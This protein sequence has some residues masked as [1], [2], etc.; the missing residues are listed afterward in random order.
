MMHSLELYL[1]F[2]NVQTPRFD[3]VVGKSEEALPIIQSFNPA[4]NQNV[5][6]KPSYVAESS[7]GYIPDLVKNQAHLINLVIITLVPLFINGIDVETVQLFLE[8]MQNPEAYDGCV[9]VESFKYNI[10][11]QELTTSD[12]AL[13]SLASTSAVLTAL[14]AAFLSNFIGRRDVLLAN[15]Y[16]RCSAQ[17]CSCFVNPK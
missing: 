8:S 14:A 9:V 16:L 7:R 1:L 3:L 13:Q 11:C 2:H 17:L 5:V 10:T 4:K 12:Y 6:L 15:R